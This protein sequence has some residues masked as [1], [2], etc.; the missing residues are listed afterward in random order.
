[1]TRTGSALIRGIPEKRAVSSETEIR[2]PTFDPV[3]RTS[4]G[5]EGSPP[6]QWHI[7]TS[8]GRRSG[9]GQATHSG[10]LVDAWR[11]P[12]IQSAP[13]SLSFRSPLDAMSMQ[14]GST[15]NGDPL[16]Y[17]H[18]CRQFAVGSFDLAMRRARSRLS[19]RRLS[20][21]SGNGTR[22]SRIQATSS[23]CEGTHAPR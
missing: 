23:L 9:S 13:S 17:N 15:K 10:S 7:D 1:M 21:G 5:F 12:S 14:Y 4:P 2:R 22:G 16:A 19:D 3:S 20:P 6:Q 8:P 11:I 18:P